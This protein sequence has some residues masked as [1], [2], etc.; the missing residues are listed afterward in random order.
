[1]YLDRITKELIASLQQLKGT[2]Q[3]GTYFC[4]I[5][6]QCY[7]LEQNVEFFLQ[8]YAGLSL[9]EVVNADEVR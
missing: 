6:T 8:K 7:S 4:D 2:N 5:V 1:M 3:L 9:L